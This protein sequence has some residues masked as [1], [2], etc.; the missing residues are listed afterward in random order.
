MTQ[1]G[2]TVSSE[3]AEKAADLINRL[4]KELK[5]CKPAWSTALKSKELEDE[6]KRQFVKALIENKIR[7][8]SV[9]EKGL[10]EARKNTGPFF[11][12]TGEFI[13]WCL[14]TGEHWEHK[15]MRYHAKKTS[16]MLSLPKPERDMGLGRQAIAALKQRLGA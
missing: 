9:V 2:F 8:W 10:A 6:T 12:S 3:Q 15:A 1:A 5:G 13:Q 4:F 11:P 14:G 16:E 7:D